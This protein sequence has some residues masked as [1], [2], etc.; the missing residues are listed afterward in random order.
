MRSADPFDGERVDEVGA[1]LVDERLER[2]DPRRAQHRREDLAHLRVARRVRLAELQLVGRA[3]V[4]LERPERR[5]RE[6]LGVAA[7]LGDVVVVRHVEH[8]RH[9]LGDAGLVPELRRGPLRRGRPARD[10][11]G[12]TRRSW[13]LLRVMTRP[14]RSRKR[15]QH[16]A[17]AHRA[18]L[19]ELAVGV[20]DERDHVVLGVEQHFAA[21]L[22]DAASTPSKSATAIEM[23]VSP[24]SFITR[25]RR[26]A[27]AP[28]A[29]NCMS[30]STKPSRTR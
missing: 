22:G 4:F 25:S 14:V 13:R 15:R 16:V 28:G 19:D 23:C 3:G 20:A 2:A 7:D 30:S 29:A 18:Q 1:D 5:L 17:P 10:R 9:Q 21:V 8:A 6:A 12:C 27:C 24:G 26:S 11:R